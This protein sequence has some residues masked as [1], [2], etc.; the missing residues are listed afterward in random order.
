MSAATRSSRVPVIARPL[1]TH[2]ILRAVAFLLVLTING[3]AYCAANVN[4]GNRTRLHA[5]DTSVAGRGAPPATP[6]GT[7]IVDAAATSPG[8]GTATHPFQT[9]QEGLAAAAHG[10]TIEVRPGTYVEN[11]NLLG[12]TLTLVA[13]GGALSTVID[14]SQSGPVITV[15]GGDAVIEGFTLTNGLGGT[16]TLLGGVER[17]EAGAVHVTSS[18]DLTVRRCVVRGNRG[19][20]GFDPY[21]SYWPCPAQGGP[22]AVFARGV[23]SLEG[24]LFTSNV[25]GDSVST[26]WGVPGVAASDWGT[27]LL[28]SHCT[29]SGNQGG[30]GGDGG[31]DNYG[32]FYIGAPGGAGALGRCCGT[33]QITNCILFGNQGGPPGTSPAGVPPG[34]VGEPEIQTNSTSGVLLVVS[35]SNI[36]GGFNG[37]GNISTDPLW[38]DPFGGDFHLLPN[39]PCVDAGQLLPTSVLLTDL[40]GDPR[41]FHGLPDMGADETVLTQVIAQAAPGAP[42]TITNHNLSPGTEYYNLFTSQP[43]GPTAVHIP[44]L[45]ICGDWGFLLSQFTQPI[46][47]APF[48]FI[49]TADSMTFGPY[50]IPPLTIE[51]VCFAWEAGS[52]GFV[53]RTTTFV[54]Q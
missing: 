19:G 3:A 16:E 23:V 11:L 51:G 29:M 44:Q 22:G 14:G 17:G 12:K 42:I 4:D 39:S 32:G 26:A 8:N 52:L 31:Y 5:H 15:P 2:P 36:A 34:P 7:L 9:I 48:H 37:T 6:T 43:C 49:A 46:G 47:A 24:C 41:V 38:V 33:T 13:P 40:D 25:G 54:V 18:G 27:Q 45:G 35:N 28:V 21:C 1:E 10:D 30:R 50:P 53:S 20:D